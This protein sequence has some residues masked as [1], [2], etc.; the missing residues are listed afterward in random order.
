MI[1]LCYPPRFSLSVCLCVLGL[2]RCSPSLQVFLTML[3]RS[4]ESD[5][6]VWHRILVLEVLRVR[7]VAFCWSKIFTLCSWKH[8][9]L[10]GLHCKACTL[11]WQTASQSIGNL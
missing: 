1:Q 7:A 9:A 2:M 5:L 3:I 4:V 8:L 10:Q 6:P 11:H